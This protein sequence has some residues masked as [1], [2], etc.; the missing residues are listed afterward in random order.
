MKI[1]ITI[2]ASVAVFSFVVSRP[3]AEQPTVKASWY[4]KAYRGNL[5]ADGKTV[6]DER[7]PTIIAH[8]TLPFGTKLKINITKNR[9]IIGTV[10]DRGPWTK[11]KSG[12]YKREVDLSKAGFVQLCGDADAGVISVKLTILR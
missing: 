4:G 11:D 7:D 3:Y 8:R 1:L 2:I 5:C 12:R 9:F 10:R 6:F